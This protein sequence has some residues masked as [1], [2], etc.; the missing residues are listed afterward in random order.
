M[1][2]AISCSSAA[3]VCNSVTDVWPSWL[4]CQVLVV[5]AT[6]QG[7][8]KVGSCNVI[9]CCR[10]RRW[11]KFWELTRQLASRRA[12]SVLRRRLLISALS[13]AVN[14]LMKFALKTL[15][16]D[17][18]IWSGFIVVTEVIAYRSQEDDGK[19][20]ADDYA[21]SGDGIHLVPIFVSARPLWLG[22]HLTLCHQMVSAGQLWPSIASS[23]VASAF[24]NFHQ[25]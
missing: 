21:Y 25:H 6:N 2:V 10:R 1:V 3:K 23:L 13:S 19:Y 24:S 18:L 17:A 7:C 20:P 15:W 11:H 22:D 4:L 8:K 14:E 12:S 16:S 5:D 9:P